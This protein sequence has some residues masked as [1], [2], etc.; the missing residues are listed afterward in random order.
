MLQRPRAAAGRRPGARRGPDAGRG[1]GWGGVPP[2]HDGHVAPPLHRRRA[3]SR[4]S[5]LAAGP[6]ARRE[7]PLRDA[8]VG[9]RQVDAEGRRR[10]RP[11][12]QRLGARRP[13][14][15]P[16]RAPSS[17]SAGGA[18]NLYQ[19]RAPRATG[20][21]EPAR[22]ERPGRAVVEARARRLRSVRPGDE[23]LAFTNSGAVYDVAP[24]AGDEGEFAIEPI[25]ELGSRVRDAVLVAGRGGTAV[26]ASRRMLQTGEVALVTR[27]PAGFERATRCAGSRCRSRGSRGRRRRRRRG[28]RRG[29]VRRAR[30]RADPPLLR[31][32]RTAHGRAR[33]STPG[34][35]ARA[36]SPPAASTPI[37][38]PRPS[39]C[40]G[41][42]RK[43][44]SSRGGPAS[45]GPSRRVYTDPGGGHWLAAARARRPQHD[46]R[47]RRRRVQL[48]RVH[49]RAAA[50]VR[51][52]GRA[53]RIPDLYPQ[54]AGEGCM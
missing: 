38:G 12:L 43:C 13:R 30:R 53:R 23:M 32:R 14:S 6:R 9:Q 1:A 41:T 22:R 35:R 26:R 17:T 19:A 49:G 47:A 11:R 20:M 5:R 18:G 4:T 31:A 36:G 50:R 45:P 37:R 24:P 25:G 33:S 21:G 7:G 27:T 51:A 34:R 46:R 39:P 29:R 52:R 42:R 2:V 15:R 3:A 40:S 8:A 48:P 28:E 16:S 10:G 44:R 54:V